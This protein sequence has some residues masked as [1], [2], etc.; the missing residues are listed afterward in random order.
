M[1]IPLLFA[2]FAL[3]PLHAANVIVNGHFED[4][5]QA[6]GTIG[7]HPS[8]P[9]WSPLG[10]ATAVYLVGTSPPVPSWPTTGQGGSGQ[11]ID[12][13][14]TQSTGGIVQTV[15]IPIGFN[16]PELSWYD[17]TSD[18]NISPLSSSYNV[19]LR[20]ASNLIVTSGSFSTTVKTWTPRTLTGF[21]PL[22]TG[23]Y[24]LEFE[25]NTGVGLKDTLIDNVQ[26]V[27]EPSISVLVAVLYLGGV[28][29][30]R[31]VS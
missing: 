27:P 10:T 11:F 24:T 15:T 29:R 21:G 16:L 31:R 6:S 17:A 1:R 20:N 28:F 7:P 12:I 3:T 22:P 26:L 18:I 9:G 19:R 25:P 14:N 5:T 30:R 13:G 2:V 4:T 8:I 23:I